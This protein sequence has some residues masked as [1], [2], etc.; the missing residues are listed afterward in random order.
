L[1]F[2]LVAK[3]PRPNDGCQNQLAA[4]CRFLAV[5]G[6]C[7]ALIDLI[8]TWNI[9]R[10]TD[11]ANAKGTSVR[12]EAGRRREGMQM[13]VLRRVRL[14]GL[15]G[16]LCACGQPAPI[17]SLE[18]TWL[19]L[20]QGTRF[21]EACASGTTIQYRTDGTYSLWGE[22]G[23]WRLNRGV[24]TETMT[25][26]DPV[27]GDGRPE[28]IGKAFVS[29]IRWNGPDRFRKRFADGSEHEFRRCPAGRKSERRED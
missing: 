11:H 17:G 23:R 20:D 26:T 8:R 22:A 15:L 10:R 12:R 19:M 14:F 2:A 16:A 21:P 9:P 6:T 25:S 27:V 3:L 24:L 5:R 13:I 1:Q 18:G 29:T 7:G 4:E 28:D